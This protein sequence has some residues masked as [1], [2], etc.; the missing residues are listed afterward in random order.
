MH[1]QK[2]PDGRIAVT[3]DSNVWNM[4]HDLDIEL[5]NELPA[6]RF[7]I[8][9]PRE[10]EIE[11]NA[12]PNIEGKA[13][14]R[15]YVERQRSHANVV[16]THIFGFARQDGGP[17]RVGGFGFGTFQSRDE[18]EFYAAVRER[19]LIGKSTKG[20]Q[21]S[22]NEADAAL[23]ASSFSSVVLTRDARKAGPLQIA[24]SL[25]GKIL[26]MSAFENSGLPLAEAIERCYAAD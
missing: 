7:A 25:G 13:K 19:F 23:G 1:Y 20:S 18:R 5:A 15:A 4:L 11:L 9:L 3:I 2:R 10:V 22:G 26:D 21:L 14:L 8:F 6:R 17:E 24:A 12:I 16:V